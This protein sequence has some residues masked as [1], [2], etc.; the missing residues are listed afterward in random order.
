MKYR[1]S[2]FT[3]NFKLRVLLALDAHQGDIT[4]TAHQFEI[5][6]KTLAEWDR[7][8][9]LI[10]QAAQEARNLQQLPLDAR[11]DLITEQL[12]N[13]L[14]EKISGAKLIDTLRAITMIAALRARFEAEEPPADVY[15]RLNDLVNRYRERAAN[16]P[17]ITD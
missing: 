15:E 4:R 10:V 14:P 11:L 5:P 17:A 7:D 12:I 16:Q 1:K 2:R 8:R 13:S 9:D 6:H 3:P